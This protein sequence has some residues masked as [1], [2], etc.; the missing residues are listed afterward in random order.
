MAGCR[1]CSFLLFVMLSFANAA[2]AQTDPDSTNPLGDIPV[3]VQDT[4]VVTH[5]GKRK[6]PDSGDI[7]L[8]TDTNTH[9]VD[10]LLNSGYVMS[11]QELRHIPPSKIRSYQAEETFAYANDPAYWQREKPKDPDGI[12]FVLWWRIFLIICGAFLIYGIYRLS[13]ENFTGLFQRKPRHSAIGEKTEPEEELLTVDE[14]EKRLGVAIA[15]RD[16]RAAVRLLYLKLIKSLEEREMIPSG[17]LSTNRAWAT[18]FSDP[19]QA[20]QFRALA[21]A[22]EYV[23]YGGF[24]PDETQFESIRKRFSDFSQK[25][26]A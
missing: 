2:N 15:T 18:V 11:S 17:R 13:K 21:G 6:T 10:S 1:V 19:V 14:L 7:Y 22:Y 9:N 8:S 3:E 5:H 25:L 24:E 16:F 26:P 12:N 4:I 23:F 20:G